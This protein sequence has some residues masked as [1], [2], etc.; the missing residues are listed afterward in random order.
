MT[1]AE[2]QFGTTRAPEAGMAQLE[3]RFMFPDRREG[4]CRLASLSA[5]EAVMAT[6]ERPEMGTPI[7]AYVQGFGRFEG[8]VSGYSSAG[9]HVEILANESQ[10]QR[11]NQRINGI[12]MRRAPRVQLTDSQSTI[13]LEGGVE[14]RC[15]V[16]D[17]SLTGAAIETDM[18]PAIGSTLIIGKMHGRVARHFEGGLGIE[19]LPD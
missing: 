14:I 4:R 9:L 1:L 10:R 2:L 8:K 17:I 6:P 7:I 3:V 5:E 19:F 12:E 13:V 11:L 18:R 16:C 15:R